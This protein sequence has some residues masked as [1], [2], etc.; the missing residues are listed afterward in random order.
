MQIK[1]GEQ[2]RRFRHRAG[3]TQEEVALAL[4]VTAQAISRW[5]KGVS[6]T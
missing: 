3:R 4:G 1:L 2:I 6:Q 5:E